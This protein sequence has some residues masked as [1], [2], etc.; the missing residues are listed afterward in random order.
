MSARTSDPARG[1]EAGDQLVPGLVLLARG[2]IY[3]VELPDGA[4]VE[5]TLRGRLKLEGRTGDSVVAGDRV[6]VRAAQDP[7][8]TIEDVSPRT[9]ELARADPRRRGRR[10]KVIVANVDRLVVVFAY[11]SPVPNP[12]LIDRFLVL[13]EANHLPAVLVANKVDLVM[14]EVASA[15]EPAVPDPD[16]FEP[17]ER[18]GYPVLRTSVESGAGLAELRAALRDSTSVLTGPSGVGKSSLLNALWPGLNLRV[19]EVSEAVNKGRHTTVAA[20]LIPLSEGAYVADTPGLRELGL[21]GVD[22]AQLDAA[23]V[24]FRPHLESCRFGSSCSHTHEPDC[25]VVAALERGEIGSPR[26][27]SYKLLLE[28]LAGQPRR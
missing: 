23:F 21:W 7:T 10:A 17:Y 4:V 3:Q 26:Y 22:P 11:E 28:D 12:R 15:A 20:R 13:A 2:G 25:A 1:P 16:P 18:I 14:T 6:G 9:T 19:G 27:E 24:E 5:A 8:Y